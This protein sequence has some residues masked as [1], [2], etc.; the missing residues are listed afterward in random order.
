MYKGESFSGRF[1][2]LFWVQI[3]YPLILPQQMPV[4]R[5]KNYQIHTCCH[6][7]DKCPWLGIASYFS[8]PLEVRNVCVY[9]VHK[10]NQLGMVHCNM[11]HSPKNS[12][13]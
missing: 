5:I 11:G 10:L 7:C 1:S 13:M 12:A 8:G 4:F 2:Y 6:Q 3:R 9:R